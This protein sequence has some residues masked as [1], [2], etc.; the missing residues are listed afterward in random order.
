MTIRARF[1]I[2]LMSA[3][4][5]PVTIVAFMAAYEFR[6][7]AL[8]SFKNQSLSEIKKVDQTFSLYLEGLAEDVAFFAQTEVMKALDL[9]VV[10]YKNA[11]NPPMNALGNSEVEAK[12]YK[13]LEDFGETH[14]DLTYV[15]LGLDSSGY[16]QWPQEDMNSYDPTARPWYASAKSKMSSPV[17]TPAYRD[18][19][20]GDPILGYTHTFTG[21]DGLVGA[22]G[23]DVSLSK[24]TDMVNQIKFG[25]EGYVMLIEET[26]RILAD[27]SVPDNNFKEIASIDADYKLLASISE[28]AEIQLSG[29]SWFAT[30]YTS[31]TSGW[32]F[33]GLMPSN[34]VFATTHALEVSML[35]ISLIL[36]AV[37]A[38]L[39]YWMTGIITKPMQ[40]VTEGMDEVAQGEGDL[41]KRMRIKSNDETG[42]M[43]K[44]FNQFI[45]IV[46]TLV[47]E[48]RDSAVGVK[49]QADQANALSGRLGNIV[50]QQVHAIDQVTTAFNEMVST[51]NEVAKNCGETATAADESQKHVEQGQRFIEGTA[52]SADKLVA[53][54]NDSNQAMTEL[55]EQS[56]NITSILD[57]IRGIAEQ[58]NLLALN[59]AIEAARAGEQG[60]GFAVVADEVRTLA[61]KTATSTEEIDTLLSNLTS[62]T[63]TVSGKLASSIEHSRETVEATESTRD[64]FESIQSSV[65]TIRDMSTQIAAAAEE[66]YQVGEEIQ[67]NIVSISEEA[68][69]ANESA[70]QLRTNSSSLG[71]LSNEL[72]GLVSRFKL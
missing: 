70:A 13:L 48:I 35:V 6:N 66:Q 43:A 42:L 38:C 50:D 10:N 54:I 58:T 5:L 67:R 18:F 11:Q 62:Q 15:Y 21:V 25:E 7:N 24:L 14:K 19:T 12:A 46:H 36:V 47:S 55:V 37:F 22:V 30:V 2:L 44:A 34:E 57:T 23:I 69:N 52:R 49:E 40:R 65:S 56:A 39:G 71:Q 64:V 33:I 53:V 31:P 59:A 3:V 41:T 27:S 26:G 16:I 29:R 28:F 72:S 68:N 45:T 61:G 17:R 9:S 4:V 8:G 20:T 60:R 63:Q 32:K 51:S 1:L